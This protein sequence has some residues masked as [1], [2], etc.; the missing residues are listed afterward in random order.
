MLIIHPMVG[1]VHTMKSKDLLRAMKKAGW[2]ED[3][4][5]GSHHILKHPGKPG[6]IC[7]P[8][9]KKDLGPGLTHKLLKRVGLK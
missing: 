5:V 2:V 6:H 4:V 3:R 7:V 1:I 8:H 9:T